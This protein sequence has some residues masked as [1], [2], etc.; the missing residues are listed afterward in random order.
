M[1]DYQLSICNKE[2]FEFYHKHSLDFEQMNILFCNILQQL[3]TSTDISYDN[4]IAS[5]ILK[6]ISNIENNFSNIEQHLF[7][8]KLIFLINLMNIKK[9]TSTIS[10]LFY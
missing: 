9:I 4:N 3:I 6:K 8:I 2:V 1:S 5:T 10:N 7:N